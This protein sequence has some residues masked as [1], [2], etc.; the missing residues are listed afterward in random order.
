MLSLVWVFAVWGIVMMT[1][2]LLRKWFK[3]DKKEE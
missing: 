2:Y 3:K 1:I